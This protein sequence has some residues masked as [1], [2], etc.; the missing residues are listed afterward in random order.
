MARAVFQVVNNP[1]FQ[2][3]LANVK[4]KRGQ[5]RSLAL[6]E[7]ISSLMSC[8]PFCKPKER[9][10]PPR[11]TEPYGQIE[12]CATNKSDVSD[13]AWVLLRSLTRDIAELPWFQNDKKQIIPFWTGF[14]KRLSDR[15]NIHVVVAYPP[16]IDAKPA[17]MATVYTTMVKCLEMSKAAGQ[18]NPVQ[19]FD[20][21][22]YA[23]AQQVKWSMPQIFHPHVVRLGGFHMVSC[24]ISAIGKIWA[25]A[26]LRDLLV[27]SGAYAGCTVDQILQGK[28]F[29]R[30]VRAYTLAYETVMALWFK[31]FFQW[32][33]N[34]RKI[35]NIDEKFWQTMHSCHNA[36]S[37]TLI[38]M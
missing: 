36:F 19:T 3:D 28:Q 12:S 9:F 31:K 18:N 21:Q 6:Y 26:G 24:Y 15:K 17:D 38:Q 27:D 20:Q 32:C 2:T 4:I 14:H 30:G 22:L 29:N 5:E 1:T 33:S 37:V 16:I 35:A 13:M 7:N 25:S 11:C 34:Q 23:I 8:L 10:G